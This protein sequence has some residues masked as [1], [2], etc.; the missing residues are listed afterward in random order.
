MADSGVWVLDSDCGHRGGGGG[1]AVG[2][3]SR[4][5][6]DEGGLTDA[7]GANLQQYFWII[8]SYYLLYITVYYRI[9]DKNFYLLNAV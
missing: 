2:E 6:V 8:L 3:R 5:S 9:L 1:G 7:L 4:Q